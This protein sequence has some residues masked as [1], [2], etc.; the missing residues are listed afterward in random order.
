MAFLM[1]IDPPALPPYAVVYTL[2]VRDLPPSAEDLHQRIHSF[3]KWLARKGCS[4]DHWVIEWTKAGRPHVHGMA[5][6]QADAVPSWLMRD[7]PRQ[8]LSLTADLRTLHDGQHVQ[9]APSVEGWLKYCAKHAARGLAHYQRQRGTLPQGWQSTGRMWGASRHWPQIAE[10]F[11]LNRVAWFQYR[12]L[13]QRYLVAQA[14]SELVRKERFGDP[15]ELAD[16]RASLRFRQSML[17]FDNKATGQV[18]GLS[19][20]IPSPVSLALLGLVQDD[21]WPPVRRREPGPST[22]LTTKHVS[23]GKRPAEPYG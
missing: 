18:R 13:V 22:A 19:Q 2:T 11:D 4:M 23:V 14:R 17:R 7:L 21:G 5:F 9:E 3:R 6:W 10:T 1:G 16:A 20:W 8:W 12:R 15:R